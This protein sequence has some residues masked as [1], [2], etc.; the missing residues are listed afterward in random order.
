MGVVNNKHI[1]EPPNGE[2]IEKNEKDTT[3]TDISAMTNTTFFRD[4]LVKML[5]HHITFA[6]DEGV[7]RQLVVNEV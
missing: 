5:N 4:L 7:M 6:R 1:M 2:Q 3:T